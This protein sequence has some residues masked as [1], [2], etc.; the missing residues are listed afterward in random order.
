MCRVTERQRP[1]VYL[2][3]GDENRGSEIKDLADLGVALRAIKDRAALKAIKDLADSSA[4]L[5]APS[6]P[7]RRPLP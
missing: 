5:R 1:A 4:A 6:R 2:D 3:D 7:V